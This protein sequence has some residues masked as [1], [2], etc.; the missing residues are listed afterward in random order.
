MR[1]FLNTEQGVTLLELLIGMVLSVLVLSGMLNLF[2]VQIKIWTD[3]KNAT[4]VQQVAHIAADIIVRELRYGKEISISDNQSLRI[5]KPNGEINVFKLGE[6]NYKKT[7]Y[8]T[9]D[10][11]S[12]S[13]GTNPLTE[14]VVTNLHFNSY[15]SPEHC[16]AVGITIKVT[17][18]KTGQGQVIHTVGYPWNQN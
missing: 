18:Q 12:G 8:M 4:H 16:Q 11:P 1:K 17:D 5:T 10:K 15:L 7:L 2:F 9:I 6:G 14:N 13:F 3:E